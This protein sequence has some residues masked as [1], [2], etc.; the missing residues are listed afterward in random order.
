LYYALLTPSNQKRNL[1]RLAQE[2]DATKAI[3]GL[4]MC[5]VDID[6]EI[7]VNALIALAEIALASKRPCPLAIVRATVDPEQDVRRFAVTYC[8]A[9]EKHPAEA[10]P[11]FLRALEYDDPM[12]RS[13]VLMP[14]AGAAKA[15]DQ[16]VLEAIKKACKDIDPIV[17]NNAFAALWQVTNDMQL[18][19]P[20]WLSVFETPKSENHKSDKEDKKGETARLITLGAQVKIKELSKKQPREFLKTLTALFHDESPSLRKAAVCSV[21]NLAIEKAEFIA[22]M[23]EVKMESQLRKLLNDPDLSVQNAVKAALKVLRD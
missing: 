11:L 22:L 14:L 4:A 12:V 13:C 23:E 3:G 1:S 17:K 6:K 18:V 7:R 2:P 20:Y 10:V 15:Q 8:P 16:K 21:R 19:V 5:M 9:F